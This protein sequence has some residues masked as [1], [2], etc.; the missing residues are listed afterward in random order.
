MS[1]KIFSLILFL[2]GFGIF[3]FT[4]RSEIVPTIQVAILIA[5]IFIL[6]FM[7]IQPSKKGIILTLLGFLLSMNIALWGL[8][9]MGEGSKAIIFSLIRSSILAILYFLPYMLDR[10]IYPKFKEKGAFSTLIFPII[11]TAIFF[12][13]SLEGPFDG[14]GMSSKYVY[15]PLMFK[16]SISVFG[17]WMFVFISSWFAS[18]INYFWENNFLLKKQKNNTSV[19]MDF[20]HHFL[21]WRI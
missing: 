18:I 5:P 17:I 11:V 4:R 12:L 19:F 13:S 8:F 21:I 15:G 1:K 3:M 9:D 16:Q 10:L 2:L 6:R 7:R 14:A 20:T